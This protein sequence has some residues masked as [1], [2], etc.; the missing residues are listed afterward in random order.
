MPKDSKSSNKH[1]ESSN[2]RT[3][4]SHNRKEHVQ[5]DHEVTPSGN[6]PVVIMDEIPST[7]TSNVT[8][9][10][11]GPSWTEFNQL[12]NSVK[13]MHELLKS[14]APQN[15]SVNNASHNVNV[16][17]FDGDLSP[18]SMVVDN[19]INTNRPMEA[20]TSSGV[21]NVNF[22]QSAFSSD[23]R[24]H[25]PVQDSINEYLQSFISAGTGNS[26]EINYLQPGRPIDLKINEKMRQ[27]IWSN[28][29]IDIAS[30]L[31]PQ[32][33]S[34]IGITIISDPGE[35]IKFAQTKSNIVISSLGQWCSAFEIFITIYCQK[36]PQ[37]LSPLMS[38]MNA[39]KTLCHKGGD[40]IAYDREFRY[41]K[42]SVNLSWDTIHTG[43]WLECRDSGKNSKN[44]SKP[45]NNNSD[46][47]RGKQANKSKQHPYGYCFRYHSFGKCGRSSC[48]FKH[49]C[50]ECNDEVHPFT[51]C[52]KNKSSSAEQSSK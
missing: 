13:E 25:N 41:M 42:Q 37:A 3:T 36:Q 4:R 19:Q 43:L 17:Q 47:F 14:L 35:P 21:T 26:G 32:V 30:L 44:N 33:H 10:S 28:Q 12:K 27:K 48:K 2:N 29:Y 22:A 18:V 8:D 49:S 15:V 24:V 39:V 11:N 9:S 52:P 34:E 45:K 40:Y 7:S 46:N 6:H 23:N 16:S 31:D 1:K 51:R 50:Y 5:S 20:S 38:Y